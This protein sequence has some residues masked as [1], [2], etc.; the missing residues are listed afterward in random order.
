[1]VVLKVQEQPAQRGD[2]SLPQSLAQ[3]GLTHKPLHNAP[4]AQTGRRPADDQAGK[5]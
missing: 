3:I 1:M 4:K 5:R 2:R